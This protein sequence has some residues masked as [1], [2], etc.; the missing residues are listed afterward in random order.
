MPKQNTADWAVEQETFIFLTLLEAR[1]PTPR[2]CMIGS[3]WE[4]SYWLVG[5][6]F[7]PSARMSCT[8]CVLTR[9]ESKPLCLSL[10]EHW[11]HM[12][13]QPSWPLLNLIT[14]QRPRLQ[15]PS[16]CAII[17]GLDL[18]HVNF[19]RTHS[20]PKTHQNLLHSNVWLK[21]Y[22]TIIWK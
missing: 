22:F 1:S 11:S 3:W 5:G 17:W 2:R 10:E 18:Q 12:R 16:L 15:I 20:V 21:P 7:L 6:H 14:S 4:F 19:G 13:V 9:R 8:Y